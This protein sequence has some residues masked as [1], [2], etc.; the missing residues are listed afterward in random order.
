MDR[1]DFLGATAVAAMAGVAGM[2]TGPANATPAAAAKG[3]GVVIDPSNLHRGLGKKIPVIRE[4]AA[5]FMEQHGLV[6]MIALR[7]QNV[8]YLTNTKT[9]L[10]AFGAE[11]PAFATIPRDVAQPVFLLSSTGNSWETANG[12]REVPEVIAFSQPR[13]WQDYIN[14]TPEQM[15]VE[16]ESAAKMARMSVNPDAKLTEREAA[17][18]HAQE[19]YNVTSGASAEW[20]LVQALKRSGMAR[21]KIAVD[22]MRIAYLL[23]GIGVEG[24]TFVPGD[25]IFRQIRHVKSD[26]EISLMRVAQKITQESAMAAARSLEEG[27]TF[28]EFQLRFF[29]EATARGGEPGFILLGTTQG[30]LPDGVVK[31]GRSYMMDCSVHFDNYQGDF[32]RTINIGEPSALALQRFKAQQ[33]AREAAFAIIKA[34]VPFAT[35]EQVARDAIVK[36]GMPRELQHIGLHSVGLQHGDDPTRFDTPYP[37]RGDLILDENMTVTLD[38][39][40]IEIG[41]GAGHNEDLLRITKTGYEILNDP[42]EPLVVV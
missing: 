6:G 32:A 36:A 24:I 34:G 17:W 30:L 23:N 10:M 40:Y 2:A 28:D 11:Y 9:T 18:K 22:D 26:Y 12:D 27:M 15:R 29:T 13:N 4:R 31:R 35:V 3:A 8:F 20:A 41:W 19:T 1:R 37:I 16:P 14:P 42:G 38:L 5:Q 33:I 21:G 25:N 39:P 7:P